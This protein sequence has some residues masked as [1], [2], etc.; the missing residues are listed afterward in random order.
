[1]RETGR[2]PALLVTVAHGFG[3][4]IFLTLEVLGQRESPRIRL[5]IPMARRNEGNPGR[6]SLVLSLFARGKGGRQISWNGRAAG[7]LLG[8]TMVAIQGFSWC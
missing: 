5:C 4:L 3:R 1:M 6:S 2:I 7:G 8:L